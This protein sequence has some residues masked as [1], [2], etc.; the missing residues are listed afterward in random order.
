[1]SK[2][3]KY[4]DKSKSINETAE[5][6]DMTVEELMNWIPYWDGCTDRLQT[7]KD[8][9]N[10][11]EDSD[12]KEDSDQEEYDNEEEDSIYDRCTFCNKNNIEFR[13]TDCE[14]KICYPCR[15]R[16]TNCMETICP[17]CNNENQLCSKCF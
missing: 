15:S 7:A 3:V 10:E 16:C 4:F 17:N 5:K 13:C 11:E 12:E 14:T 2:G 1:M 9:I 6:Y 8:Y